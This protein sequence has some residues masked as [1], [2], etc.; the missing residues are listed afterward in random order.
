[1]VLSSF[2][3]FGMGYGSDEMRLKLTWNIISE[4]K[5]QHKH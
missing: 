1:M 5:I 2:A 3:V 4:G